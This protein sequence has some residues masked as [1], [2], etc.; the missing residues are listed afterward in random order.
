[1]MSDH[2][3]LAA[4]F[5]FHSSTALLPLDEWLR[6]AG[7]TSI[8]P[9]QNSLAHEERLACEW[10]GMPCE[11]ARLTGSPAFA[12]L[13]WQSDLI[14]RVPDDGAPGPDESDVL[15]QAFRDACERLRPEVAFIVAHLDQAVPE[16][17]RAFA[18][19]RDPNAL[20]DARLGL[21]Y[22]SAALSRRWTADPL[23]DDRE[24][25]PVDGGRLVFA[26]WGR[27]RWF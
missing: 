1:M 14:D 25:L 4:V 12:I 24:E 2:R 17:L 5:S 3:R 11:A 15:A 21:L 7:A 8:Q 16:R 27:Q 10:A 9:L 19:L 6:R 26:G 20:A 13:F 23:R 22:V 18:E